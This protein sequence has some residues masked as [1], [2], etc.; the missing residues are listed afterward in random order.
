MYSAMIA[1]SV[2]I[3]LQFSSSVLVCMDLRAIE[4]TA[5]NT[6]AWWWSSSMV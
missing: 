5:D 4:L 6:A 2:S 1:G 3:N